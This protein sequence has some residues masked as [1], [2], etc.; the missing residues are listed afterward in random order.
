MTHRES[1]HICRLIDNILLILDYHDNLD[2]EQLKKL[3]YA[4]RCRLQEESE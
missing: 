2:E 1:A 3:L 4:L